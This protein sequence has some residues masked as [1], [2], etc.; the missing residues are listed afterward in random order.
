MQALD[1]AAASQQLL[2]SVFVPEILAFHTLE[3]NV[4][5]ADRADSCVVEV[6]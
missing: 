5:I 3:W 6:L 1:A 2:S 4:I